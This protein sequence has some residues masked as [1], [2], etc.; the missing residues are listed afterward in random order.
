MTLNWLWNAGEIS[1]ALNLAVPDEV[2]VRRV[3][4]DSRQVQKGDLF[5]AIKGENTD[6]HLYL[7]QAFAQGATAA[8]VSKVQGSGVQLQ[9]D[10]TLAA[11]HRLARQAR[12]R[13]YGKVIG[14]TGSVGKTTM[15]EMLREA[16]TPLGLT[17]ATTG[18]LNN[19]IGVPLTW[20]NCP[21]DAPYVIIE[22]GMNHAG[23]IAPLS[24]LSRPTHTVIT[25]IGTAHLEFFANRQGIADAKAEIFTGLSASGVAILNADNDFYN[26]LHGKADAHGVA[27][28]VSF[29][30][31]EA[32]TLRLVDYDE[33]TGEATIRYQQRTINVVFATKGKGWVSNAL[34]AALT[35]A[36]VDADM[37]KTLAR[38][39][40][41]QK[42]AGRGQILPLHWQGKALTL[43]DDAYNASPESMTEALQSLAALPTKA[44][45][46]AM[47]GDMRELG[48]SSPAL[49]RE[50]ATLIMTLPIDT[51]HTVGDM[52]QH[53]HDALPDYRRGQHYAT[54]DAL[55]PNVPT[56][57][58]NNDIILVKGSAGVK[59]GRIITYLK[60]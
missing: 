30:K 31:H 40:K 16:L 17:Y 57:L 7:E 60:E 25:T 14:V 32:A 51:V 23:E 41:M 22:M 43:I 38:L 15:K 50:L 58:H 4:I 5:V 34:G 18:N 28:T 8:I 42:A 47:L 27:K 29:G 53:L 45:R 13:V 52:M 3:V 10:D 39:A 6:G 55:L 33:A 1:Y 48:V 26:Y 11:L 12:A 2:K 49:H 56:L 35:A 54:V 36:E 21:P 19:H 59:M 44:R 20:A 9:V 24:Q 46:V 37:G